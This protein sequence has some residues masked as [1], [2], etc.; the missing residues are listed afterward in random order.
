M[1]VFV[2]FRVIAF[3][4]HVCIADAS[5]GILL[6]LCEVPQGAMMGPLTLLVWLVFLLS[7]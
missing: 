3:H 7:L 4:I 2:L 6:F 1:N 5:A